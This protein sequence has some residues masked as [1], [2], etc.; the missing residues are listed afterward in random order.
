MTGLPEVCAL[1]LEEI[2]I[3]LNCNSYERQCLL[4]WQYQSVQRF[5]LKWLVDAQY[6]SSA[7]VSLSTAAYKVHVW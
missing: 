3:S 7:I 2:K 1:Q 5:E 4:Y 6:V